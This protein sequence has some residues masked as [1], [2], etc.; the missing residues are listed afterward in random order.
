MEHSR[1]T[2]SQILFKFFSIL[3]DQLRSFRRTISDSWSF[4]EIGF[5]DYSCFR[6]SKKILNILQYFIK[7]D[8]LEVIKDCYRLL[9]ICWNTLNTSEDNI[10]RLGD[11]KSSKSWSTMGSPKGWNIRIESH[12]N[13]VNADISALYEVNPISNAQLPNP[14]NYSEN[15]VVVEKFQQSFLNLLYF[16]CFFLFFSPVL[17]IFFCDNTWRVN[18]PWLTAVK[19]SGSIVSR[20]GNPGGLGLPNFSS[21]VCGA[22]V[23][24]EK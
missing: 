16:V 3:K 22:I 18:R 5:I 2:I 12:K 17:K 9:M 4:F 21:S 14:L 11:K 13:L 8:I 15:D 20:P 1:D 10:L 7:L 24:R 23:I 6:T 19:R